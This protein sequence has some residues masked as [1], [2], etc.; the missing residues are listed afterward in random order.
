MSSSADEEL[1]EKITALK[2]DR[3]ALI[4]AHNFQPPEIQGIADCV[5]GTLEILRKAV[6]AKEKVIVVCGVYFMAELI[7]ALCPEKVVLIPDLHASCP[8]VRML[9]IE[10]L[11]EAK[12]ANPGLKVASY[13]KSTPE[14]IAE[15]DYCWTSEKALA[16]LLDTE[17]DILFTPN[18][19]LGQNLA[20]WS[21]KKLAL[22]GGYCPP[23][24][25]IL[26]ENV[27]KLQ[28]EHP[29]AV[30][31]AHPE[32]R[33][34]VVKLADEVLSS[35][36]MVKFVKGSREEEFI[37]A[38]ELGLIHRISR[39]NPDKKFYP[40]STKALCQNMKLLDLGSIY[41]SM[42]EMVHRVEVPEETASKA[43][44]ILEKTLL[45]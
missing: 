22:L 18:T 40:A 41:W 20:R 8:M 17:D 29:N 33:G 19:H 44:K 45:S 30:V 4:I 35:E 25:K 28:G 6:N 32:C 31:L 13:I 16:M 14:S 34:D 23:H 10:K 7:A 12:A 9:E 21:G 42:K 15:S 2:K 37:I 11:R 27:K 24:V 3:D 5:G 39:E 26:A 36:A 43:A 38:T 1:V